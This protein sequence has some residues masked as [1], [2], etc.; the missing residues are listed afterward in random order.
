MPAAGDNLELLVDASGLGDASA[1]RGIGTYVRHLLAGLGRAAGVSVTALARAGS[2][3]PEGVQRSTV[4]RVAPGQW[5]TREHELLLPFDVR[6]ARAQVFHSPALDPPVRSGTPWVQTLHDVIP[7]V[8]DD[9]E[10]AAERARWRRHAPRYRRAARIIAVSRHSAEVGVAKLGLDPRRVEVIHHGVGDEFCPGVR[11]NGAEPYL[12]MVSEYSRRKGYP[13]AFAMIGALAELGYPHRLRVSGRVAPWVRPA[14]ER[15]VAGAPR[16][17]RIEL[18]GYVDDI[19]SQY[20]Q[21]DA[22]IVS[23]RYE[24]FGLPILEAMACGTPVVSFDNSALTEVAADAAV[25][26]PDG[27]VA[28]MTDAVRR[29]LDTP[30]LHAELSERGLARAREQ[31]WARSTAA[32]L[33]VYRDTVTR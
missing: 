14:V 30:S 11:V 2:A 1:Y 7:L 28:A 21:A 23:S 4:V 12:L 8:F 31:T 9:A 13:E 16:P 24:G 22:V 15:L 10:L 18:I 33:D 20:Q 27:D 19:V 3:L 17:D 25:L 6:R 29:V 26:V 32:H 5:R